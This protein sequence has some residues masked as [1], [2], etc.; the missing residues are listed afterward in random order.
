M[1]TVY[2]KGT[3]AAVIAD[4]DQV[5]DDYNGEIEFSNG[6]IHGRYIGDI[7]IEPPVIENGV[8]IQEA[9]LSGFQ[10]AN[11]LVPDDFD[12][13]IFETKI[14]KPNNPKHKFA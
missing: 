7:V 2:L 14:E 10:H 11:L 9:V 5:I 3:Q 1:K 12:D 6:T 8:V 13:T 4:I